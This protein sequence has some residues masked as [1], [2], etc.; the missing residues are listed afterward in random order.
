[1]KYIYREETGHKERLEAHTLAEAEEK[2]RA[3]LREGDWS[4]VIEDGRSYTPQAEILELD[5][6]G[7]WDVVS[8]VSIRIDP[9]EPECDNSTGHEWV[10][11]HEVLGGM[12]ENPGV[13]RHRGGVIT[14]EVCPHC[15]RY[16][17][18]DT[19]DDL[20]RYRANDTWNEL[21]SVPGETVWYEGADE[22]SREWVEKARS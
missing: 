18:T 13:W 15:G 12:E 10:R 3:M 7:D 9:P 21:R 17:V 4:N 16:R 1:M 2:A 14:H 8:T 20:R 5:G 11:P 22:K 6:D 19:W